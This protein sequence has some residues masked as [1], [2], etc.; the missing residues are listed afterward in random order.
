MSRVLLF[1]SALA[2]REQ[3]RRRPTTHNTYPFT[4]TDA[5]TLGGSN[6]NILFFRRTCRRFDRLSLERTRRRRESFNRITQQYTVLYYCTQNSS[7]YEIV[8]S[9]PN[10]CDTVIVRGR[11]EIWR[12]HGQWVRRPVIG[13]RTIYYI[14]RSTSRF[15]M[16]QIY[17][18]HSLCD[19]P[20]YA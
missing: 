6:I 18:L 19:L 9:G 5:C 11:S 15:S 16:K 14:L 2:A 17:Y 4:A 12:F 1:L 8:L 20:L 3:R 13:L 10:R 7:R